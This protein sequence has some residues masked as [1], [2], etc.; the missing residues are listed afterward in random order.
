MKSILCLKRFDK[1]LPI[2]QKLKII[3]SLYPILISILS[4]IYSN[5][6]GP[7]FNIKVSS[8]GGGNISLRTYSVTKPT[9]IDHSSSGF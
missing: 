9:P 7:H 5:G 3:F 1:I 4:N 8:P 6:G 2:F